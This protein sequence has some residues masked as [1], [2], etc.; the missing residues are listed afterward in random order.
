[1]ADKLTIN[2]LVDGQALT[3]S[4]EIATYEGTRQ[5]IECSFTFISDDWKDCNKRAFSKIRPPV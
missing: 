4:K 2:L 1:M 3:A 5:Y